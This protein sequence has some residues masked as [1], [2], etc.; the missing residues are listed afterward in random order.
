MTKIHLLFPCALLVSVCGPAA[1]LSAQAPEPPK[2]LPVTEA[3]A[4][5]T[6]VPAVL[7]ASQFLA[8]GLAASPVHRVRELVPTDGYLAH[9]TVD[10]DF[11]TFEVTGT[12]QL[13]TCIQEI[14]AI[15]K[16]SSISR[17]DV[18]ADGLRRSLEQPIDA[19]KN[20]VTHPVDTVKALPSTVG[21]FF[22]KVGNSVSGAASNIRE[23]ASGEGSGGGAAQGLARAGK[24][25]IGYDNAKLDCAKQLGVDPYSDNPRLQEDMDK[26]SWVF[27]SGGLPLRVGAMATGAGMAI[28]AT[29]FA[30]L[31]DDIYSVTPGEL[32]LRDNTAMGALLVPEAERRAFSTNP[33]LTLSL[34]HSILTSLAFLEGA[35]GR[36]RVI[37]LAGECA[38][39]G[40]ARFLE[41]TLR[42]MAR[43]QAHGAPKVKEIKLMG[44]IPA[45]VDSSGALVL[46]LPVDYVSWTPEVAAFVSR[47]DLNGLKPEVLHTGSF[48][49]LAAK[50]LARAGWTLR[51]L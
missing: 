37:G 9:Y 2:A 21:H 11:G 22:K 38:D 24:G 20:V 19:A 30:G 44:R 1:L 43:R 28:S 36:A 50:E 5:V 51:K 47:D 27:W 49:P 29:R 45:A 10:S 46:A 33:A 48:S 16:L 26:I 31:P 42:L 15:A 41:E 35:Q 3:P 18:F 7:S 8:P 32:A 23:R 13:R 6:E 12:T 17:S 14:N 25:I 4:G 39:R 40:Q 34:R